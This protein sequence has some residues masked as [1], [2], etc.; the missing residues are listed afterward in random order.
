MEKPRVTTHDERKE[1][2]PE[3]IKA[4]RLELKN[5][6][7]ILRN[8]YDHSPVELR[9]AQLEAADRLETMAETK[10]LIAYVDTA[11]GIKV[12][13]VTDVGC[14]RCNHYRECGYVN[15]PDC[16]WPLGIIS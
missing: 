9:Q 12:K 4:N 2:M 6:L 11:L 3:E 15:C 10:D 5:I 14:S 16:S 7:D 8:P 13:S 1:P